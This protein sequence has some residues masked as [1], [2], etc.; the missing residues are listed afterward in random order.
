MWCLAYEMRIFARLTKSSKVSH[1]VRLFGLLIVKLLSVCLAV[2]LLSV[3]RYSVT[4]IYSCIV[5]LSLVSVRAAC[6][7]I[8]STTG[9]IELVVSSGVPPY[10]ITVTPNATVTIAMN[11]TAAHTQVRVSALA[12]GSYVVRVTDTATASRV[13]STATLTVQ[14]PAAL[15]TATLTTTP[16]SHT[17]HDGLVSLSDITGG[18]PPYQFRFNGLNPNAT[19]SPYSVYIPLG[20][21]S[22]DVIDSENCVANFP[23]TIVE[24]LDAVATGANLSCADGQSVVAGGSISVAVTGGTPPFR[25]SLN[26]GTLS[27]NHLFSPLT[28]GNYFITVTDSGTGSNAQT[29]V[30]TTTIW[31]PLPLTVTATVPPVD[32]SSASTGSISIT[33][34]GGLPP[35]T[36][37]LD[38]Q[39]LA[40]YFVDGA[41][42]ISLF[43]AEAGAHIF[44]HGCFLQLLGSHSVSVRDSNGCS[45]SG[46]VPAVV[47]AIRTALSPFSFVVTSF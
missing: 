15:I 26:N 12:V 11:I 9:Q 2:C 42:R 10:F 8:G 41:V 29:V 33:P 25:Y 5:L 4:L 23:F 43:I 14:V 6:A 39:L 34:N 21:Y 47:R 16:S 40:T 32:L 13:A 22:V 38:G 20:Q 7:E 35:Y 27:T 1:D 18:T 30:A 44:F 46:L 36:Y 24:R 37:Y 19:T 45:A 28:P 3:S 17:A 31:L